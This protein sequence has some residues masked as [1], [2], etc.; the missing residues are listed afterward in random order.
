MR[1]QLLCRL[2]EHKRNPD[3]AIE[4]IKRIQPDYIMFP[5]DLWE[6]NALNGKK[7]LNY[8]EM[9]YNQSGSIIQCILH[10]F[11]KV[12]SGDIFSYKKIKYENRMKFFQRGLIIFFLTFFSIFIVI[13]KP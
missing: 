8:S 12:I 13:I 5:G 7:G 4:T 3:N 10:R 1:N 6:R 11:T 9:D 2:Q